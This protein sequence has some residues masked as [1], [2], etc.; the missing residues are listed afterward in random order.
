MNAL[1]L[2]GEGEMVG[3]VGDAGKILDYWF[4]KTENG[5]CVD[6]RSPL[7]FQTQP[8]TDDYIRQQFGTLVER[9]AR[10]A[11]DDWRST[12]RGRLALIILLDQFPR[13]IYRGTQE[14]FQH[15]R[16]A[17][18]IAK[19]GVMLKHDQQLEP[20][21]RV[22]FYLPFEHAEN[23][24]EQERCMGLLSALRDELDAADARDRIQ[25]YLGYAL[26]HRDIVAR[27]ERFPHRNRVLGRASTA[28]EVAYLEN[29]EVFGQ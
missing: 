28:D 5:F 26:Q 27:F 10:G 29:T 15:D 3:I 25:A 23:I 20:I 22:F 21:E 24:V 11:L 4:G 8:A 2:K 1:S 6:D 19:E 13:N 18:A 14:A 9:A 7:W 17:L 12:P 16:Q